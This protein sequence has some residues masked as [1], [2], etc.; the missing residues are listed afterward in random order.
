[1]KGSPAG[2]GVSFVTGSAG[3]GGIGSVGVGIGSSTGSSPGISG[4][5]GWL[6]IAFLL[7]SPKRGAG[8]SVPGTIHRSIAREGKRGRIGGAEMA[9]RWW[10]IPR[11][12]APSG[13]SG[14]HKK[15]IGR[16]SLLSLQGKVIVAPPLPA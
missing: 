4:V 2:A 11:L 14:F 5:G 1:M 3:A 6:A 7:R 12:K 13:G 8:L 15:K 16:P 9:G 10:L